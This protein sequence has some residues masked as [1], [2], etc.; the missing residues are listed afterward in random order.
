[1]PEP[2]DKQ[3]VG[4]VLEGPKE[5]KKPEYL[6]PTFEADLGLENPYEEYAR[7]L[8]ES[9]AV[10]STT[11]KTHKEMSDVVSDLT[12]KRDTI[13][14][15]KRSLSVLGWVMDP[16]KRFIEAVT[17]L[18]SE[19][20]RADAQLALAVEELLG[21]TEIHTQ[22]Q[23]RAFITDRAPMAVAL[24][25]VNS[26]SE[27]FSM[28]NRNEDGGVANYKPNTEESA[29][30]EYLWN[31]LK[32]IHNS[33]S[34]TFK[35]VS[36]V[37]SERPTANLVNIDDLTVAEILKAL[38]QIPKPEL[39]SNL[40]ELGA[41]GLRNIMMASGMTEREANNVLSAEYELAML[42][43]Q[44]IEYDKTYTAWKSGMENPATLELSFMENL[45]LAWTQPTQAFLLPFKWYFDNVSRPLSYLLI[46]GIADMP[47]YDIAKQELGL[48]IGVLDRLQK[49]G[50]DLEAIHDRNI[51][52]GMGEQES[53]SL[54]VDE[55]D[56]NIG[57]KMVMEAVVD[58]LTYLF[59]GMA[60]G[61]TK[62]MG[63]FGR[64]VA[65][66]DAVYKWTTELPFI[67]FRWGQKMIPKTTLNTAFKLQR[68]GL[69]AFRDQMGAMYNQF[70]HKLWTAEQLQA[71]GTQAY[72]S[73]LDKPWK[74]VWAIE[75]RLGEKIYQAVHKLVDDDAIAALSKRVGVSLNLDTSAARHGLV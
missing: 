19:L 41:E 37:L 23:W 61:A 2:E 46:Q 70:N 11:T 34:G 25:T 31:K 45:K 49:W 36:D 60:T 32:G 68:N 73:F 12:Q 44:W 43:Q 5:F 18:Q 57:I 24:G 51:E 50:D 1:M 55:W 33:I 15:R 13:K 48:K 27:L 40:Q 65:K 63:I 38:S 56:Q 26:A 69:S 7:D 62:G 39:P 3:P 8:R 75:H 47:F 42:E 74:A 30:A 20:E 52:E 22:A 35:T 10:L 72:R 6:S 66:G 59:P 9:N 17:P 14:A 21:I 64:V 28:L 54:A 16:A 71:A 4:A 53:M 58:P 67:G 29:Y